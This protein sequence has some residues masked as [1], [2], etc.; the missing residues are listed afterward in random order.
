MQ[1]DCFNNSF[2]YIKKLLSKRGYPEPLKIVNVLKADVNHSDWGGLIIFYYYK[3]NHYPLQ[4]TIPFDFT[5][6]N[7]NLEKYIWDNIAIY[8]SHNNK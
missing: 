5:D 1:I 8:D 2:N 4:I 6:I 7:S 3:N